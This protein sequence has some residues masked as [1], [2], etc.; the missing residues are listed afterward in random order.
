MG[1]TRGERLTQPEGFGRIAE[2]TLGPLGKFYRCTADLRP[3]LWSN[4]AEVCAR[5]QQCS[6]FQHF[7]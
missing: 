3:Y 1:W 6:S 2:K 7:L 4:G 5:L